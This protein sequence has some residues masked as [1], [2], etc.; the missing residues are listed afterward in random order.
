M[1]LNK[2]PQE[3]LIESLRASIRTPFQVFPFSLFLTLVLLASTQLHAEV[4]LPVNISA[5]SVEHDDATASVLYSGNVKLTQGD[6]SLLCDQL[7][8]SRDKESNSLITATGSPV[9]FQQ[10]GIDGVTKG[11]ASVVTYHVK[12]RLLHLEGEP[13][14]FHH[15]DNAGSHTSGDA[16]SAD[17]DMINERLKM[18]GSPLRIKHTKK[19]DG[20][21]PPLTGKARNLDYDI[22]MEQLIMTG[23]AQIEQDGSK[24]INDRI[25]FDLKQMTAIAGKKANASERVHTTIQ[26]EKQ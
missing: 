15:Q 19:G 1:S 20:N 4:K 2:T 21:K 14:Q 24:L 12:E 13:L 22:K 5:D 11:K 8:L 16:L 9:I 18:S 10:S 3:A 17:Y 26:L 25:I 6:I 7:Q 23:D